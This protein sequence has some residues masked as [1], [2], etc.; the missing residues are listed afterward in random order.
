M[1]AAD[2][3]HAFRDFQLLKLKFDE[4]LSNFACFGFNC[5]V[6]HYIKAFMRE[7]YACDLGGAVQVD[8]GLTAVDPTLGTKT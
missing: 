8:P 5:N 7:V 2:P 6:R 4:L 1:T 3:T